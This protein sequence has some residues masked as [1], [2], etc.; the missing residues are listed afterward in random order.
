MTAQILQIRDYQSKRE[1]EHL[2]AQEAKA[3]DY[4]NLAL[5]AHDRALYESSVGYISPESDPA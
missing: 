2:K 5:N 4:L 1:L 3:V